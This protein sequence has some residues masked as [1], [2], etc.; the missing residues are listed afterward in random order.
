MLLDLQFSGVEPQ[1]AA[2]LEAKLPQ[3]KEELLATLKG[4]SVD[5]NDWAGGVL[6]KLV[7]QQ[8]EEALPEFKAAVDL[9]REDDRTI[10]QVVIYPV[11]QLV[12]TV[13][14]ELRSEAIPNL[15]LTRLKNKYRQECDR[16][17]GLPVDYMRR[18]QQEILAMLERQLGEEADVKLYNLKPQITIVPGTDTSIEII[19]ASDK[20]KIWLEGYGD[21]GRDKDNLSGKAHLGKFFSPDDEIFGEA[22]IIL[23]DVRW[24][25]GLGYT[26][27]W[28]KS[29]WSYRYRMPTG[30]NVYRLE[31]DLSSRWRLRAERYSGENRN[32]YGVRYRIHE[33]LSAECVYGG[34][35][36]YLRLIGNL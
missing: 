2:L 8:T 25:F 15:L 1:T 21:I 11:G 23:D 10:I 9:T 4:A 12:R 13:K 31:Y 7:R 14:Y 36:W 17:R 5:A 19:L 30:N 29:S 6:R 26:R 20:Y 32:E 24:R 3:L 34:G 18:C 27:Y 35:E 16:L 28:G 22:E 33:F